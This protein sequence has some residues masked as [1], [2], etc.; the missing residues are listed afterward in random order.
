MLAVILVVT[1]QANCGAVF[2]KYTDY[3]NSKNEEVSN[4]QYPTNLTSGTDSEVSDPVEKEK[5]IIKDIEFYGLNSIAEQEL[6][7]KMQMKQGGDYSRNLLQTDLKAIY[8]TGYFTS[9][10]RFYC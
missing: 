2:D 3:S 4:G 9:C 5:R 10:K 6:R 8:E 1:A 7:E